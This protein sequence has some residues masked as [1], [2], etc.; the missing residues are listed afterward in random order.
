MSASRITEPERKDGFDVSFA[1]DNAEELSRSKRY[2][3]ACDPDMY[4]T[5]YWRPCDIGGPNCQVCECKCKFRR[6]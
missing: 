1:L 3:C 5:C 4:G 2:D 6:G